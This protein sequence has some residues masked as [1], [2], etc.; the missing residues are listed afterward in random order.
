MIHKLVSS[1]AILAKTYRDFR[2][3]NSTT[4]LG[5]GIEWIGELMEII[6]CNGNYEFFETDVFVEDYKAIIPCPTEL[7]LGVTRNGFK[8]WLND[9]F[10][11]KEKFVDAELLNLYP[12]NL[13]GYART[14]MSPDNSA[15]QIK[16]N[17]FHFTFEHGWVKVYGEKISTDEDGYPCV[18]SNIE[19]KEALTWGLMMH[20]LGTGTYEHP[21]F[22]FADAEARWNKWYP[23][24]QNALKMP[25]VERYTLFKNHVQSLLPFV[26]REA[27]LYNQ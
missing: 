14:R 2:V 12:T 6:G 9:G 3:K 17:F 10:N 27:F 22:K 16:G 1:K 21:V 19:V 18:P 24:A 7:V 23:K 15:Y 4:F 8:C 13:E 25:S 20:M 11:L 5:E 26:N